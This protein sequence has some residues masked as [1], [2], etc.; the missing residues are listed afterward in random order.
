MAPGR[1]PG[2]YISRV[3]EQLVNSARAAAREAL[4]S[5]RNADGGWGYYAGKASRVESTAWALL[6]LN[7]APSLLK[8]W[9]MQGPWR[10]DVTGAPVNYAS[11]AL[12]G[13]VLLRH[14]EYVAD[15]RATATA[16][17][18]VK[19]ASF[20]QTDT[21]RQDNSLQAWPWVE[22]TFSWVE[23]TALALLLLKKCRTALP[24]AAGERIAVGERMLIDRVCNGGGWNYGGSNVFGQDLFPYVP[25]TA[26][27]VMALQDRPLENAVVQSLSR[28][29]REA[30]SEP[31]AQALALAAMALRI[32]GT[33][34]TSIENALVKETARAVA[35]NH[36]VGLAMTIYA[37]DERNGG[38]AFAL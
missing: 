3:P 20:E 1:F 35:L 36:N 21:I 9:P 14:S 8:K 5:A 15:A 26:W 12:A 22:G 25:T 13:L 33:P 2:W 7:E 11:Q 23:P 19:G 10:V 37:L 38:D 4:I 18:G 32:A 29:R 27:G 16:L 6:A 24:A 30:S 28:L 34:D 17:V 31:T